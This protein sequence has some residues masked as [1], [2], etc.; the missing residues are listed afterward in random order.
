MNS[1]NDSPLE[2]FEDRLLSELRALR[3]A[4]RG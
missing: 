4:T 1:R 3:A 2:G